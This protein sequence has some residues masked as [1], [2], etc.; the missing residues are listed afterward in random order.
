MGEGGATTSSRS[1]DLV[2]RA[3]TIGRIDCITSSASR[4]AFAVFTAHARPV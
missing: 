4:I 3:E 1:T 2:G